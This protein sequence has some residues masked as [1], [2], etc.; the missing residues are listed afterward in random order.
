MVT[1][2]SALVRSAVGSAVL[3]VLLVTALVSFAPDA[4]PYSPNNYGWNGV[5]D[6]ASHYSVQFVDS[7]GGLDPRGAELLI[8]QPVYSFTQGEAHD[9]SSFA[10]SGGTVVLGGDSA[11]LNSLLQ[12]MGTGIAV[13]GQY[14]VQDATYNWKGEDL[15]L[16]LVNPPAAQAFGF[17]AGVK[18]V[19]MDQ[20]SPLLIAAGSHA[21]PVAVSSALSFEVERSSS[22]GN[23][24][25]IGSSPAVVATGPFVLAAA[26]STGTGTL[27]VV[28]DP[29][30]FANSLWNVAENG[31]LTANLFSN[32]TVYVDT[33]HWPAITVASLKAELG[34]LYSQASGYPMRYL[35]TVAAVLVAVGTLPAFAST[36]LTASGAG[37]E[38]KRPRTTYNEAILERVRKDRRKHGV[39]PG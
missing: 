26:E 36:D 15:P 29:L 32:S 22:L 23:L 37:P 12:D 28:G 10:R 33:S 31:V 3:G 4:A 5:R 24:P 16:A 20:P 34:T 39:Q 7:L 11:S 13:Q 19:A 18:G 38:S 17:L 8:M 2:R 14:G 25:I 6:L 1:Q 27:L 35:V 21:R 9:V 30:L